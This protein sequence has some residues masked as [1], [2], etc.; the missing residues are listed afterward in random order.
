[1]MRAVEVI[2]RHPRW[3]G[4]LV[5]LCAALAAAMAAYWSIGTRE[6]E[7][8]ARLEISLQR[9]ALKAMSLTLDGKLMGAISML[10]L[11]SPPI[12]QESDGRT[13]ANSADVLALL[14]SA[15]Q[16]FDAQAVFVVNRQGVVSSSWDDSG[17]PSTGLQISFRPYF[18][19]AVRGS[20]N[21]YA[22]ISLS[23]DERTLYFAAPVYPG[24][25]RG[26]APIGAVV[27][28]TGIDRIDRLL[29]AMPGTA[30]L[31]SPQGVV[32]AS[33]RSEW[34]G[35]LAVAP[36]Q[37][38][39]EKIRATRQFG[40]LFER[41]MP[42]VL[43]FV[44]GTGIT[45]V[46]GRRYAMASAPVDWNDPAGEWQLVLLEDLT[47]AIS[48]ARTI[49]DAAAAAA[50]I[51]CIGLLLLRMLRVRLTQR[52]ASCQLEQMAKDQALRA[53]RR[54]QL[55]ELALRMQ[56]TDSAAVAVSVFLDECHRLFGALQGVV[57]CVDTDGTQLC[58]AGAYAGT[59]P[60][61]CIAIGHGLL[62]QCA[63]ERQPRLLEAEQGNPWHIHSG[64]GQTAPAAL[65]LVPVLL[66]S[67]LLGVVELALPQRPDPS[68]LEQATAMA[69]LLAI[70][71][72]VS[73]RAAASDVPNKE[74]VCDVC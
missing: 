2:A 59:Q 55:A 58:L 20:D 37:Q 39:M 32:F 36:T 27:A 51:L 62:G 61:S 71:L 38:Q 31:L 30:L 65:L 57:Y 24:A 54:M 67:R 7:Y 10:G 46:H 41:H 19:T 15:A 33:N 44:T 5:L 69:E 72:G 49:R 68:M 35:Q 40:N 3:G 11:V 14:A 73:R 1:M 4:A 28:R 8:Q 29:A 52:Q 70:N 26:G 16:A 63:R 48:P 42:D 64:L 22:A 43:P 18:Q 25:T 74:E 47:H 12:K 34:Q 23:R 6:R 17:K 60:P 50:V 21:V 45:S 53:E 13:S 56:Q 66:Q 9:H